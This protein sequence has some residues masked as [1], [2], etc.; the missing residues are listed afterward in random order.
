MM[1]HEKIAVVTGANRGLGFEICRQLAKLGILVILTGR[2][3]EQIR[4]ACDV[5]E[6]EELPVRYHV[7]DVDH[8]ASIEQFA[9]FME[10]EFGR[11]DIL[12]NNAGIFP[13]VWETKGGP[14]LSVFAVKRETITVALTTNFFGPLLMCQAII[15][16]M[17][18]NNYGRIVNMSSSLGQLSTM[19]G[20][21]PAYR[22]SKTAINTLTRM[23]SDETKESN[24]LINS[25]CPGWCKTRMGGPQA[26]RS[27]EEGADTAVY[28]ATLA[29]NGP[30]GK[31]FRDRQEMPW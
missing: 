27:I 17:K 4:V 12:V 9:I 15:P 7:L 22:V 14:P 26:P 23:F 30:R 13:D 25:M 11:C 6:K 1:G 20:G 28:L 21:F 2:D 19:D 24:I 31:F 10:K 29:D 8:A 18:K 16:L 3:Q 5:L